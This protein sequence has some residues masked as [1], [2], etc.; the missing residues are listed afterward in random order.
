MPK[1]WL[2]FDW[3]KS[4]YDQALSVC[5]KVQISFMVQYVKKLGVNLSHTCCKYPHSYHCI[6]TSSLMNIAS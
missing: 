4:V 3:D 1:V 6:T 5:S 2:A